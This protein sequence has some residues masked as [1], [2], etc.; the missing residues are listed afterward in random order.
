MLFQKVAPTRRVKSMCWNFKFN[1]R[2][3]S[4]L[5]T[6]VVRATFWKSTNLNQD[7]LLISGVAILSLQTEKHSLRSG[8]GSPKVLSHR[9]SLKFARKIGRKALT[10]NCVFLFTTTKSSVRLAALAGSLGIENHV[11]PSDL[12]CPTFNSA[13]LTMAAR[14]SVLMLLLLFGLFKGKLDLIICHSL[15]HTHLLLFFAGTPATL[16]FW[17][18]TTVAGCLGDA[19]L[20][21]W[22]GRESPPE[23]VRAGAT[24]TPIDTHKQLSAIRGR[25]FPSL[26]SSRIVNGRLN[27][28]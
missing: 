25:S 26:L 4:Q 28:I 15:S 8:R 3:K 7:L 6:R 19:G 21:T 18:N 23:H 11:L 1:D 17:T 14:T 27:F 13:S 10:E 9:K 5:S 2:N 22:V 12:G 20:L 24:I 16:S